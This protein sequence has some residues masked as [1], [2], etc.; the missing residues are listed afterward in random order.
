MYTLDIDSH[1][2]REQEEEEVL[3]FW[4]SIWRFLPPHTG[5]RFRIELVEFSSETDP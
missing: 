5:P 1:T 2:Q 4:K 3:D